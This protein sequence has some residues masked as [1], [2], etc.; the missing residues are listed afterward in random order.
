M[1]RTEQDNEVRDATLADLK[2]EWGPDFTANRN[3]IDGFI[4]ANVPAEAQ[5]LFLNARMGDGTPVFSHPA[6]VRVFAQLGR[7]LNPSGTGTPTSGLN[8]LDAIEDQ[9][10]VYEK[11][12]TTKEWFKDDKANEHYR[13][14]VE[15]RDNMNKKKTA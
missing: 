1:A 7:T 5:P 8:S 3:A 15:A 14:L 2:K 10:K 11:R 4:K 13:Q 9:I 6:M 12:M